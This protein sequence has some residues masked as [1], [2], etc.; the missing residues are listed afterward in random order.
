M[1]PKNKKMPRIFTNK[2]IQKG[3]LR[4]G[5]KKAITKVK[6]VGKAVKNKVV[7]AFCK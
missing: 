7:K 6:T 1:S 2:S 4:P 3:E 5:I